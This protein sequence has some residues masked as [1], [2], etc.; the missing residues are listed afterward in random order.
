[1]KPLQNVSHGNVYSKSWE[2]EIIIKLPS[3][4]MDVPSYRPM[5][6]AAINTV[7]NVMTSLLS[8]WSYDMK[9]ILGHRYKYIYVIN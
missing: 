9:H 4:I 3:A 2:V 1:M 7:F 5:N 6:R 8:T